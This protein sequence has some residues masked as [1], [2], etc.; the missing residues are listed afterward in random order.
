[1]RIT[2]IIAEYNPLHLGHAYHIRQARQATDA[3]GIVVVMSG[4]FVQRGEPAITDKF[5]RAA[6]ALAAGADV[7]LEL[8][9]RYACASAEKFAAGAAEILHR[10]GCVQSLACGC[11]SAD[12]GRIMAAAEVLRDEPGSFRDVLRGALRA[13]K[14][15]PAAREEAF[16]AAVSDGYAGEYRREDFSDF[17]HQPNNILATEYQHALLRRRAGIKLIPIPRMQSEYHSTL[18]QDGAFASASAVRRALAGIDQWERSSRPA[19]EAQQ[20]AAQLQQMKPE[21]PVWRQLPEASI[22]HLPYRIYPDDLTPMLRQA[23]LLTP[24]GQLSSFADLSPEIAARI[25][26]CREEFL[27]FT[28]MTDR[29][30]AKSIPAARVRRALI[31]LLLGMP[32]Q[33][34]PESRR[35]SDQSAA[36][37][38]AGGSCANGIPAVRL[39]GLRRDSSVMKTLQSSSSIPIIT[40]AADA[41]GNSLEEDLLAAEIYRTLVS[42]QTGHL[43]PADRL[44]HPV[45]L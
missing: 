30:R 5:E 38:P 11:E 28:E 32:R 31:H 17:L 39:L 43:L 27:S 44:R 29:V 10:L 6:M 8:P 3:D 2:G 15:Y 19:S 34:G 40:K 1:M 24:P 41:P 33:G 23:V 36:M 12:A 18:I 14:S 26:G 9:V 20:T 4:D 16:L 37:Q 21:L 35:G 22:A 42:A 7:V 25:S 13:V 45:I